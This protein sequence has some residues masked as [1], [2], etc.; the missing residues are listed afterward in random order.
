MGPLG[1]SADLHAQSH[2]GKSS[3]Q[4]AVELDDV[5]QCQRCQRNEGCGAMLTGSQYARQGVTVSCESSASVR[6]GQKV[7]VQID[8]KGSAWLGLVLGAYGLPLLGM[9]FATGL[10]STVASSMPNAGDTLS[11]KSE[12]GIIMSALAGFMGAHFLWGRLST[13][14]MRRV[15]CTLCLQSAR[16]VDQ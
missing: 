4:F 9:L 10:A 6:P 11:L 15:E 7:I 1:T 14:V 5:S 16:I 3:Y 2:M 12:L 8:E 13:R